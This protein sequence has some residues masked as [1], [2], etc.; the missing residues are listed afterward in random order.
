MTSIWAVEWVV[1]MLEAIL[2]EIEYIVV[3]SKFQFLSTKGIILI[4]Y[5]YLYSL[6]FIPFQLY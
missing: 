1:Q 4:V 6:T 5:E 2:H 3:I